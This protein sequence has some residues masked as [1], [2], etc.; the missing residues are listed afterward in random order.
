M[1]L[2]M[3][4]KREE[5]M[6]EWDE[7]GQERRVVVEQ[8]A[9]FSNKKREN[10]QKRITQACFHTLECEETLQS[11]SLCLQDPNDGVLSRR[12]KPLTNAPHQID[13]LT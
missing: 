13:F 5:E 3:K 9:F 6:E 2:E 12:W 4:R 1:D 10:Q 11:F 8:W 7:R